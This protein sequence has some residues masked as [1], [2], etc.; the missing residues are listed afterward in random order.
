M[1]P[2]IAELVADE[3]QLVRKRISQ[4]TELLGYFLPDG[5]GSVFG[6]LR[7]ADS[8]VRAAQTQVRGQSEAAEVLCDSRAPG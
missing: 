8:A 3:L 6:L 1:R 5:E 7:E 2:E 4:V